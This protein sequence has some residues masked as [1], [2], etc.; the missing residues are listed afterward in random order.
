[1]LVAD[2]HLG[3]SGHFRKSGIPLP[4][5]IHHHDLLRLSKIISAFPV[6]KLYL[7]GDLFHSVHNL[8][9]NQFISWRKT[10]PS[11]EIH[12]IKGN[13]DILDAQ[14][15]HEAGI[16]LHPEQYE[17]PPFLFIHDTCLSENPNYHLSGHIH[18]AIHLTGKARQSASF[19]CF[20]FRKNCG[21]LPAFGNFTG[22]AL[23]SPLRDDE[24]YFIAGDRIVRR[25]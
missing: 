6:Q 15:I 25:S 22:N 2:L 8:E 14:L 7:L 13:H 19:P 16:I 20:W 9:W 24:V 17:E 11:L 18:P 3:K 4:S 12:L 21:V 5:A 10:F 23:I 1:L